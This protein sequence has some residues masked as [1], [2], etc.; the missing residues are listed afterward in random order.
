MGGGGDVLL[1]V[2]KAWIGGEAG[3]KFN[4]IAEGTGVH[5]D[6]PGG[7][8]RIVEEIRTEGIGALGDFVDGSALVA[9]GD[10]FEAIPDW[11]V[12][13][14]LKKGATEGRGDESG[15]GF[16]YGRGFGEGPEEEGG[17]GKAAERVEI[18]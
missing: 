12:G 9:F 10:K 8:A 6:G 1:A 16:Y 2:G 17:G 13:E 3:A 11:A 4:K 15:K 5:L 14:G 18:V 7:F